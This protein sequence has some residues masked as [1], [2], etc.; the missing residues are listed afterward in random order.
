MQA[1][2]GEQ[3][4][5]RQAQVKK[6][7]REVLDAGREGRQQWEQHLRAARALLG[8]V[9]ERARLPELA[10]FRR[11][12]RGEVAGALATVT[13]RGSLLAESHAFVAARAKGAQVVARMARR[14]K[15]AAADVETGLSEAQVA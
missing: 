12:L 1:L 5:A 8:R 11:L 9:R 3:P 13:E 6:L 10:R 2:V 7:L 14:V 4:T 15:V